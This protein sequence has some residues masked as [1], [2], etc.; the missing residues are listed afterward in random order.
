MK[1][2]AHGSRDPNI[3]VPGDAASM[4]DR[5]F[6]CMVNTTVFLFCFGTHNRVRIHGFGRGAT[7]LI[8][9]FGASKRGLRLC[10]WLC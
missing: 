5:F 8:H 6:G 4:H 1:Y 3:L 7:A 2:L 10:I 9:E